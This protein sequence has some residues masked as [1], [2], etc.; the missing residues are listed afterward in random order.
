VVSLDE[1]VLWY[2]SFTGMIGHFGAGPI[3]ACLKVDD[4]CD[5]SS[6]GTLTHINSL[7]NVCKRAFTTDCV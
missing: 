3:W 6:A 4:C 7:E 2:W 5:P 1:W